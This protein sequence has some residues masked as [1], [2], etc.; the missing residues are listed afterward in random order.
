MRVAWREG[1]VTAQ[2]VVDALGH[3]DWSPRTV[4]TLLTAGSDP[5]ITKEPEGAYTLAITDKALQ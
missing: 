3:K 5:V 2:A 1:S 4:K